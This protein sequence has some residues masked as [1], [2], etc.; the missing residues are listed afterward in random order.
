MSHPSPLGYL[1]RFAT[2]APAGLRDRRVGVAAFPGVA[3]RSSGE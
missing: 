3:E 1:A 2:A